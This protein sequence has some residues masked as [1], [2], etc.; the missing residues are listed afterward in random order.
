M[1]DNPADTTALTAKPTTTAQDF[2]DNLPPMDEFRLR[3]APAQMRPLLE[4]FEP[5]LRLTVLKVW[6]T[7][8]IRTASPVYEPISPAVFLLAMPIVWGCWAATFDAH[9]LWSEPQATPGADVLAF[10]L[11]NTISCGCEQQQ[12][13]A[14]ALLHTLAR[15]L[16]D[17]APTRRLL[18]GAIARERPAIVF[19]GALSTGSNR[20]RCAGG[21]GVMTTPPGRLRSILA[22]GVQ[23]PR[24]VREI[25]DGEPLATT[26]GRR[27]A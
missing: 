18:I 12:P 24:Y 16:A 10:R 20:P 3:D 4:L 9:D 26:P 19:V 17:T 27:E 2:L 1:F 11:L 6:A 15:S 23:L 21:A 5:E 14:G 22:S 25:Y 13:M 8:S 7:W